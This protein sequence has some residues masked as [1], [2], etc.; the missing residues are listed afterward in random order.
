MITFNT[1]KFNVAPLLVVI[2]MAC[3]NFKLEIINKIDKIATYKVKTPKSSSV[4]ILVIAI[5]AKIVIA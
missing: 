2:G 1:T 5:D 3:S 4:Q